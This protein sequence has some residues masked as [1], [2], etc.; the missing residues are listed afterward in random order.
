MYCN[1]R[2][3]IKGFF[4]AWKERLCGSMHKVRYNSWILIA[5]ANS[6]TICMTRDTVSFKDLCFPSTMAS[7]APTTPK[8]TCTCTHRDISRFNSRSLLFSKPHLH[9][10][11]W[12]LTPSPPASPR[13]G[14]NKCYHSSMSA[15]RLIRCLSSC[16]E[17]AL[18]RYK[19]TQ[20]NLSLNP[21]HL[22][23]QSE[24]GDG[25]ESTDTKRGEGEIQMKNNGK[26]GHR[27]AESCGKMV[28]SIFQLCITPHKR[29]SNL[30][31]F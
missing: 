8:N 21:K 9:K 14:P 10:H 29:L 1:F 23:W 25:E 18:V 20:G 26:C 3:R 22:V 4:S 30:K 31:H 2:R 16:H 13:S 17:S 27:K 19:A 6:V 12:K 15:H 7:E 5:T 28:K 24:R 11:T